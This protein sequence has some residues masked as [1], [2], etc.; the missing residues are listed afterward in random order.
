MSLKEDKSFEELLRSVKPVSPSEELA[1]RIEASLSAQGRQQRLS[2]IRVIS[3]WGGLAI[4]ATLFITFGIL[5][6]TDV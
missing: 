3:G 6:L 1:G 4:A 5:L 2:R